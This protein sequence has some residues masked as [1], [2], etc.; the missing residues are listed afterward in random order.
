LDRP[1]RDPSAELFGELS[2]WTPGD[3]WRP[4]LDVFE[5]EKAIVVRV[6]LG[7][8]RSQ[9]VKVSVDGDT[10]RIQG[11]R[12]APRTSAEVMRLHR[13]EIAF[14]RFER[15]VRIAIPFDREHVQAHLED[16]F[17]TIELPK[18]EP[19]RR[20]VEVSGG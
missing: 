12:H 9:D 15:T 4:A 19:A 6:E 1:R 16:G 2:E 10:L 18:R 17:L 11:A 7:G 20:R 14:G 5:T 13:M 8:V 3:R